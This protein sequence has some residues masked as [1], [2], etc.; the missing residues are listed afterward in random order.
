M[1]FFNPE[2]KNIIRDYFGFTEETMK[3]ID[4]L[5]LEKVMA[6]T[7]NFAIEYIDVN[8]KEEDLAELNQL[9]ESKD[10]DPELLKKIYTKIF[11][12][13]EKYPEIEKKTNQKILELQRDIIRDLISKLN[14]ATA[15]KIL[16]VAAKEINYL[17]NLEKIANEK[18]Q[19]LQ[20]TL[21]KT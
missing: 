3:D 5:Y 2:F 13:Y 18:Q 11:S 14:D 21:E 4:S 19:Q 16:V 20:K 7:I 10:Q 17:N 15:Q 12:L 9:I 6:M 1:L 8:K